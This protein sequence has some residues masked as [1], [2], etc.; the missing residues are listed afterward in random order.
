MVTLHEILDQQLPIGADLICNGF[1]E[2]QLPYAIARKDSVVP[3]ALQDWLGQLRRGGDWLVSEVHPDEPLPH[4][5]FH[6]KQP[7]R[8]AVEVLIVKNIGSADQ[9]SIKPIG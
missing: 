1:A 2:F 7:K 4:L 9:A 5:Q 3:K 8:R 6:L